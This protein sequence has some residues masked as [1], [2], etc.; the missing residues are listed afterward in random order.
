MEVLDSR[1]REGLQ[2][3]VKIAIEISTQ[4]QESN[5]QQIALTREQHS[6]GLL[7]RQKMQDQ[8]E[9]EIQRRVLLEAETCSLAMQSSGRVRSI[10]DATA[11]AASVEQEATLEAARIRA[12][13]DEITNNILAEVERM[14]RELQHEYE[15]QRVALAH[16]LEAELADIENKKFS[17]VMDAIGPETVMEISKAGPELQA[18][19]LEN[20]GLEGYLVMDG[21]TPINLFRTAA[22]MTAQSSA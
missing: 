17:A 15:A 21:S 20:L 5:A 1:T 12:K 3:S 14:K 22:E 18:K 8:V 2:K 19:L 7:E 10:A 16:K 4:A 13:K 11:K 9:N 6:R